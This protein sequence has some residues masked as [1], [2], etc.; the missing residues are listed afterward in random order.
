MHRCSWPTAYVRGTERDAKKCRADT[1]P[2]W[3][4]LPSRSTL[5]SFPPCTM[6]WKPGLDGLQHCGSMPCGFVLFAVDDTGRRW[7]GRRERWGNLLPASLLSRLAP[8]PCLRRLLFR[9]P[10]PYSLSSEWILT[11]APSPSPLC[12]SS[13]CLPIMSSDAEPPLLFP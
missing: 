12:H 11:E 3:G 8:V 2:C 9:H 7:V 1:C 6:P 13:K 4:R 10:S 5:S